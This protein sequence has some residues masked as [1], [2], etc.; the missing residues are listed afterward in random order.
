MS[1]SEASSRGLS[2]LEANR[3]APGTLRYFN[4]EVSE[5][6][7]WL[8][9]NALGA[10][11]QEELDTVLLEYLDHLFFEGW[12]HDRGEKLLAGL[13][14]LAPLTRKGYSLEPIRARAAL[15]GF[16]RLAHGASRTPLVWQGFL[17]I[18][19]AE[20]YRNVFELSL[21]LVIGWVGQLY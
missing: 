11:T 21:A 8:I 10:S 3:I 17:A 6:E 5:F 1:R 7:Q 19:G 16:K 13:A 9:S 20:A 2:F 14:H 4:Q 15:R 12:N 18:V